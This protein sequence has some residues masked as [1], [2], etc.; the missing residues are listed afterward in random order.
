[1]MELKV[2]SEGEKAS[3]GTYASVHFNEDTINAL[4]EYIEKNNIPNAVSTEKMHSTLLYSR[5]HLPEY[6]PQGK[7]EPTWKG[8]FKRFSIFTSNPA[9]HRDGKIL[10][11]E[12][13]C[14]EQSKRF[15]EL[16]DAHDATYDFNEYKPHTTLSY[17]I[18]DFDIEKLPKFE[19]PLKIVEEKSKDIDLHRDG[20]NRRKK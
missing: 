18:G 16:M 1:M 12:Y 4:N 13:N 17:D 3:C 9:N 15:D 14:S 5:N 19:K 20:E 7:L 10:V 2:I 6:K 8:Q 11:M